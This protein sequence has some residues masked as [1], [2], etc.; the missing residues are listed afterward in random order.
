MKKC[1]LGLFVM[2]IFSGSSFAQTQ[3]AKQ[4]LL[5]VEKLAQLKSILTD[6]KKGYEILSGGYNTI[7]NISEGNFKL[8]DLF[9]NSLLQVSPTVRKYQRITDII[10]AQ[11]HIVSEYKA[12]LKQFK[13]SRQFSTGELAYISKVYS[14]LFKRSLQNLDDLASVITANKFR[15]TDNERLSSI[16]DIWK[17]TSDELTFLR[18]FNNHTK[19]LALQRAKDHN[20]ILMM[21]LLYDV[22]Q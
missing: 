5:D 9:L 21:N 19:I 12:A 4:L 6:M 10:Q 3:E 13:L 2:I 17:E 15:M 1:V 18:H 20:D 14:N 22:K 11:I 16:D 8:H 7:K